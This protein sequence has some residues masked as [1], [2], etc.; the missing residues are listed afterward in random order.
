MPP[1][2]PECYKEGAPYHTE[3][4]DCKRSE[5]AKNTARQ[6]N[7]LYSISRIMAGKA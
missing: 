5:G 2:Q 7:P 1:N 3:L 4:K 6:E